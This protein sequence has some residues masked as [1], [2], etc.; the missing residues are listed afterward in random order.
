MST[1]KRGRRLDQGVLYQLNNVSYYPY[2][3][4]SSI[5]QLHC[6][7]DNIKAIGAAGA[8]QFAQAFASWR[9]SQCR[10]TTQARKAAEQV[11][12]P[13]LHLQR[14]QFDGTRHWLSECDQMSHDGLHL[15]SD[16]TEIGAC[17]KRLC[18]L[19]RSSKALSYACAL[20]P[21]IESCGDASQA[22]PAPFNRSMNE[23]WP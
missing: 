12:D 20:S 8:A 9:T 7:Y 11:T 17:D 22:E 4:P 1:V 10:S 15:T 23:P 3:S 21:Q 2:S 14:Q 19:V 13:T 5:C 16:D 6:W 18:E